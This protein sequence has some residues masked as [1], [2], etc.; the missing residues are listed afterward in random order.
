LWAQ[1]FKKKKEKKSLKNNQ[2][3]NPSSS[4]PPQILH[5]NLHKSLIDLYSTSR[6]LQTEAN[7]HDQIDLFHV[8]LEQEMNHDTWRDPNDIYVMYT[9]TY[10][11]DNKYFRFL[12]TKK[13][14][15]TNAT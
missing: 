5:I 7:D 15:P 10:T 3:S 6:I 14:G 2:K 8:L 12:L 4:K 9:S 11:I 1:F 13:M